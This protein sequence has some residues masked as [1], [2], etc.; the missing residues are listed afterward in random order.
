MVHS[1]CCNG[2]IEILVVIQDIDNGL[3]MCV[4]LALS[5]VDTQRHGLLLTLRV[6]VGIMDPPEPPIA[7]SNRASFSMMVGVMDD[8]GLLR[9]PA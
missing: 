3:Y 4:C 9:G 5:N 6:A 7:I 8:K 2:C 1:G